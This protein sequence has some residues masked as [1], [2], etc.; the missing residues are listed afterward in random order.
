MGEMKSALERAME[1]AEALGKA[2]EEELRKWKYIPAGE[3][4]AAHYLNGEAHL[5]AELSRYD[6]SA[7][8]YIIEGAKSILLRGIDLPRNEHAKSINRKAMEGIK[9]LKRDNVL[10][11]NVYTKMRRLF[12]HYEKEGE[13]QRRQAY[14]SFKVDFE[15]RL[16]RAIQQ[17]TGS[18][19]GIGVNVEGQ[20]Q[21]R[22][23]WRKILVQLDSQY[24]KLL[25]EYKQE[26]MAIP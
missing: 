1:K 4:L 8:K 22:E 25:E 24:Y 5:I 21:F 6:D 15:Q 10:I 23:E 14:E 12:N 19:G 20:P 17:R 18:L 9:S 13:E 3:S 7:Q 16:Q 2:S 11:E 26:L